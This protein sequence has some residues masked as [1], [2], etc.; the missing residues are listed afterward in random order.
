MFINFMGETTPKTVAEAH[1]AAFT[2]KMNMVNCAEHC[3]MDLKQFKYTFR[4]Y[5]KYNKPVNDF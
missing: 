2:G 5:L 1:E 4:E 3:G